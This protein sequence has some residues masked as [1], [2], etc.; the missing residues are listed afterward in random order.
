MAG[1]SLPLL[2]SMAFSLV[3]MVWCFCPWASG[4]RELMELEQQ[5]FNYEGTYLRESPYGNAVTGW[6]LLKY[7][8]SNA[9]AWHMDCQGTGLQLGLGQG[10]ASVC[11][12]ETRASRKG[13]L[14]GNEPEGPAR[15]NSLWAA[16]C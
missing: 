2:S 8:L 6:E 13:N 4:Q 1:T 5:I 16:S 14:S 3:L 11:C 15:G 12:G 9:T 7:V 10:L